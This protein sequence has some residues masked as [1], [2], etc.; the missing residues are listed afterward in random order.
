ME[1]KSILNFTEISAIPLLIKDFLEDR[2]PEFQENRFSLSNF[3][4]KIEEKSENFSTEKRQRI[5]AALKHQLSEITL[6]SLQ[7]QNLEIL[8][9]T[10]AFTITTGHQLNLFSGPVFFIYKIL[11]TIKTAKYLEKHFPQQHFVPMFWMATEDHD[12]LEINH[13]KTRNEYYEI[14]ANAG[15]VVGK[16]QLEDLAFISTFEEEFQD[17]IFGTELILMLK[18]AYKFGKTLTE[19]TR[20]LVNQLFADYGLLMID[21][22]DATLKAE[23]I[24]VF[25][26]ELFH[27][28]LQNATSGDVLKLS[29]AY[30]KVQVNPREI[31]LFYLT[32]TRDRIIFENEQFHVLDKN[33]SFS[34]EELLAE[35]QNH[36]EKFSPNAVMRPVF[37]ETVLPNLAYIGGNA[38]IMYWLELKNYFKTINLSFPLLIPRNSVLLLPSKTFMK[39]EKLGLKIS[40]F[41]ENFD[42]VIRRKFLQNPEILAELSETKNSLEVQFQKLKKAAEKTDVTFY[43]LVD[44]EETRQLKAFARM[45]KRLLRAEKIKNGELMTRVENLFLEVHPGKIWQERVFNFSVFYSEFGK[46][47]ITKVYDEMAVEKSELIILEL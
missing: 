31:N 5:Y 39:I 19:A 24:S 6:T 22:D 42:E 41:F 36:P 38:E 33:I 47:F 8:Q 14:Q 37:Q 15:G 32:D 25:A 20:N 45:K 9:E 12:F 13:F 21:G 28:N 43:N 34:K 27:Q 26:G 29:K 30:G 2:L 18:N 46:D 35:L 17:D 16:I 11:Q 3:K 23:M 10:N 7:Q 44:A 1:K 40:H 4:Q